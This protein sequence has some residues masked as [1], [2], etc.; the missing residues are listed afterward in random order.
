M[1]YVET[2]IIIAI[3]IF[4]ALECAESIYKT[5]V[6]DIR[7]N[8]NCHRAFVFLAFREYQIYHPALELSCYGLR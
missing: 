6:H 4:L 1:E 7:G 8:H 5:F 2:K 3:S